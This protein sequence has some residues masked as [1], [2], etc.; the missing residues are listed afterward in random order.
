MLQ[1]IDRISTDFRSQ[2]NSC[3]DT[4]LCQD[5]TDKGLPQKCIFTLLIIHVIFEICFHRLQPG[6]TFHL[7]HL[8]KVKITSQVLK[9]M[10]LGQSQVAKHGFSFFL[11]IIR[12]LV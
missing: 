12:N 5:Y 9:K 2:Q 11:H 3:Y 1:H 8:R 7:K 6:Y 4:Q 10:Y